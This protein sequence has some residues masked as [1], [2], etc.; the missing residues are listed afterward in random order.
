MSKYSSR[1]TLETLLA[2]HVP[3]EQRDDVLVQMF[4]TGYLGQTGLFD[5]PLST[6]VNAFNKFTEDA[7]LKSDAAKEVL[8][9]LVDSRLKSYAD[10]EKFGEYA[11]KEVCEFCKA[12]GHPVKP[13]QL[14]IDVSYAFAAVTSLV[15]EETSP[16]ADV[17]LGEKIESFDAD[18]GD[19]LFP[20][21]RF[22]LLNCEGGPTLII[23]SVSDKTVTN[24]GK[25][26]YPKFTPVPGALVPLTTFKVGYRETEVSWL[27]GSD[28]EE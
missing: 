10:S 12:I 8:F 1:K 5:R 7:G 2:A 6:V 18:T 25:P 23:S 19:A 27:I 20:V 15:C 16:V 9:G 14:N 24:L 3:A 13:A 17:P 4:L 26:L 28:T 11:F 22:E 21:L